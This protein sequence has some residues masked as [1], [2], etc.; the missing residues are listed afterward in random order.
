MKSSRH[1]VKQCQGSCN[2]RQDVLLIRQGKQ[3]FTTQLI[4]PTLIMCQQESSWDFSHR[5]Q[6]VSLDHGHG[7]C[8]RSSV[9]G[10]CLRPSSAVPESSPA[11][12]AVGRPRELFALAALAAL[13]AG[14]PRPRHATPPCF[15]WPLPHRLRHIHQVLVMTPPLRPTSYDAHSH[16]R[17]L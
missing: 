7:G 3:K 11:V 14:F 1:A 9:P 2:R 10:W 5:C 17:L 13:V 4:K 6:N 16:H 8:L 15:S 12:P